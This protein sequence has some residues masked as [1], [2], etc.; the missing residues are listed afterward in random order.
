MRRFLVI[1]VFAFASVAMAQEHAAEAGGKRETPEPSIYLK[2][3]NFAILAAGL[4]YLMSKTLPKIFAD[5]TAEIQ[6]NINEA[7]KVKSEAEARAAQMEA[8]LKALGADIEAF[9]TQAASDMK[10][11]GERIRQETAE[12][13]KKVEQHAALEIESAGQL[14]Q[15]ELRRYSADL[16]LKLAEERIRA[17]LD[18][19]VDA[20]LVDGF[21]DAMG[22]QGSK[23]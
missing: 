5:R 22:R 4:G 7:Q 2:W 20:A 1:A 9:R 17:R 6:A 16:A 14:A 15:R 11:E 8:R 3:A 10:H 18:A 21:V 19:S 12:Q 23:N 13:I